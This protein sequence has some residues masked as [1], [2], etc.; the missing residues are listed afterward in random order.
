MGSYRGAGSRAN[1]E[2]YFESDVEISN[3]KSGY[4]NTSCVVRYAYGKTRNYKNY[5]F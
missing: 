3:Y 4:L 1:Y 5:L 2:R